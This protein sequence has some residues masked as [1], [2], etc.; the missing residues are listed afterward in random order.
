[1]KR[2]LIGASFVGMFF[3]CDV[4]NTHVFVAYRYEVARDCLDPTTSLDVVPSE[5]AALTC[6][7]ACLVRPSP[8]A[9]AYAIYVSTMCEPYPA[10]LDTSGTDPNCAA[11]LAAFARGPDACSGDGTSSSPA[12]GG[13]DDASDDASDDANASDSAI[14]ATSDAPS[15]AANDTGADR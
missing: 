4:D 3:G 11:A 13:A 12:D 14:D 10:D 8:P 6:A 2:A 1:M 9:A 7:P 15:D 5:Q